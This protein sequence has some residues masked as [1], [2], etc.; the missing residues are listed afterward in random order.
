MLRET[1]A[2][3]SKYVMMGLTGSN[4]YRWSRRNTTDAKQTSTV[5]GT[6]TAP[7]FWVRLLRVGGAIPLEALAPDATR[8]LVRRELSR[9]QAA[10]SSSAPDVNA[11]SALPEPRAPA[12]EP[13]PP[14]AAPIEAPQA[15]SPPADAEARQRTASPILTV[16]L[17]PQ[18]LRPGPWQGADSASPR[19]RRSGR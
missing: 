11:G 14:A 18:Q 15:G 13:S 1:L 8:D 7:N 9:S 6:G 16:R 19:R 5:Y 3:G 12:A 10:L 2:T 17:R 4:G